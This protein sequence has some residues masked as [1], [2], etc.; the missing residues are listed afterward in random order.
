MSGTETVTVIVTGKTRL[1]GTLGVCTTLDLPRV[2]VLEDDPLPV[3]L[4]ALEYTALHHP[5][6][7]EQAEAGDLLDR[8]T[9][10]RRVA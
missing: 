9:D 1:P 10:A 5:D 4:T 7:V 3:I 8:L 2:A 6:P